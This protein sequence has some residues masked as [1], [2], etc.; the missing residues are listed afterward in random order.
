MQTARV[1]VVAVP[2]LLGLGGF[3]ANSP[4]DNADV[5]ASA[6]PNVEMALSILKADPLCKSMCISACPG[7]WVTYWEDAWVSPGAPDPSCTYPPPC[8]YCDLEHND[9]SLAMQEIRRAAEFTEAEPIVRLVAE[10]PRLVYNRKRNSVQLVGCDRKS[11]VANFPLAARLEVA[12]AAAA[13]DAG[14]TVGGE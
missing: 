6:R 5:T 7:N 13:R 8:L 3:S 1:V 10:A 9:M 4:K 11:I 14:R 12:V 2:V